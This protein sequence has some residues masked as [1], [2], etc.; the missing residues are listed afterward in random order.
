M[1]WKDPRIALINK[2][3]LDDVKG[4]SGKKIVTSYLQ[5]NSVITIPCPKPS[6]PCIEY[7]CGND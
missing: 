3:I 7:V 4:C 2:T 1:P 5:S 6:I